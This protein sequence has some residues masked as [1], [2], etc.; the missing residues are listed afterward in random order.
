MEH[1]LAVI[2]DAMV[3]LKKIQTFLQD[4]KEHETDL[5]PQIENW[6]QMI[7]NKQAN[8]REPELR[9]FIEEATLTILSKFPDSNISWEHI[10]EEKHVKSISLINKTLKA[11]L[12]RQ[13]QK[14]KKSMPV[15]FDKYRTDG[16]EYSIY[17][18]QELN[19]SFQYP[20]DIISKI[21]KWE[22]ETVLNM[23]SA[24]A[25]VRKKLPVPLET[26]QLILA[27][28]NPV[29]IRFRLDE[30]RFDVE[31]SYSIR[32][33]V[34]KKRI[35]KICISD[36][37][38]RLTQPGKIAIVYLHPQE[39]EAYFEAIHEYTSQGKLSD[40]IEYLTLEDVQGVTGLKAIR[41]SM[42]IEKVNES[43]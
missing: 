40:Q 20:N 16:W 14:L 11:V 29:D 33:E 34:I 6:M 5:F 26:T 35:D 13:E 22:L 15:Y 25:A 12:E 32:Y 4:K 28:T 18:G 43:L 31:G 2:E 37:Q 10:A 17:V 9:K 3:Q 19:P 23:G 39:I 30:H 24:S 36:K 21:K 41:I 27:Q 7:D 42:R 38:E 8:D 1:H